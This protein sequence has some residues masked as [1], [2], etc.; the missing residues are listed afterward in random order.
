[1]TMRGELN[2]E[3]RVKENKGRGTR[4]MGLK[5]RGCRG[6]GGNDGEGRR[7]GVRDGT[8]GRKKGEERGGERR[9]CTGKVKGSILQYVRGE[10]V[11]KRGENMEVEGLP[12]TVAKGLPRSRCSKGERSGRG[13]GE[14]GVMV[15]RG[16]MMRVIKNKRIEWVR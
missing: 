5:G 1:M 8:L 13:R 9:A 14:R 7:R 2:Y 6:E 16:A 3:K 12:R 10:G 15:G 11:R 4:V